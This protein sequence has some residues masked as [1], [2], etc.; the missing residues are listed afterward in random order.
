MSNKFKYRH[1][2][3]FRIFYIFA[4]SLVKMVKNDGFEYAGYMTFLMILST[5]PFIFLLT[6][7][8]GFVTHVFGSS[9]INMSTIIDMIFSGLPSTTSEVLK[10]YIYAIVNIP[11]ISLIN[12]VILGALWTSSSLIEGIRTILN[13][14]YRIKNPPNYIL[15]RILSIIQVIILMF[16][17]TISLII[18]SAPAITHG[19]QQIEPYK[20][21]KIIGSKN[22]L[23]FSIAI[24]FLIWCMYYFI[25]SKKQGMINTFPG[26]VVAF[27]SMNISANLYSEYIKQSFSNIELVYGGIT[28][29]IITILFFYLISLSIIYGGEFNHYFHKVILHKIDKKNKNQ[30]LANH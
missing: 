11:S 22:Y 18:F 19:L 21:F 16:V 15:R 5:F 20:I 23:F 12:I 17:L 25:P 24:F 6:A 14:I 10:P 13:K 3:I 8:A 27:I 1:F 2:I 28:S 26:T 30:Q 7:L 9:I 4:N 29:V